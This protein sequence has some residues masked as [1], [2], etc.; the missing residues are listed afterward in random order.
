MVSLLRQKKSKASLKVS[1]KVIGYIEHPDILQPAWL[2]IVPVDVLEDVQKDC[3]T[4]FKTKEGLLKFAT[5]NDK[6]ICKGDPVHI[7]GAVSSPG[8]AY[9]REN[10]YGK[11]K[12]RHIILTNYN[13]GTVFCQPGDSGSIVCKSDRKG[14]DL[15]AIAMLVG[16]FIPMHTEEYTTVEGDTPKTEETPL[17]GNGKQQPPCKLKKKIQ[18]TTDQART[19]DSEVKPDDTQTAQNIVEKC[20]LLRSDDVNENK[21]DTEEHANISIENPQ[22]KKIKQSNITDDCASSSDNSNIS[23][24]KTEVPDQQ[25]QGQSLYLALILGNAFQE[26]SKVNE[27]NFSLCQETK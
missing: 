14:V 15:Y 10:A 26:L 5:L 20:I 24:V 17:E 4:Q 25:R 23:E 7:W 22:E 18:N 1:E 27:S 16:E 21:T 6:N 8:L 3:V 2:D 9:V 11:D 19:I 13:D 12:N